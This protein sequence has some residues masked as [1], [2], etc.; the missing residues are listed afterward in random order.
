MWGKKI[1]LFLRQ[2]EKAEGSGKGDVF[3]SYCKGDR[4]FAELLSNKLQGAGFA[5][6]MDEDSLKAGDRWKK[7]IEQGIKK[8][9]SLIV[10]MSSDATRSNWVQF[11]WA[12]AKGAGK[13]IIPVILEQIE[14]PG[15][16][17]DFQYLD[18]NNAI[19][20]RPWGKLFDAVKV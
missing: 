3:I 19:A 18:F 11:E 8:A 16:L 15:P 1:R 4:N 20:E 10:L 13:K 9:D 6:W 2:S 7:E 12:Y 5:V 14:L 17:N